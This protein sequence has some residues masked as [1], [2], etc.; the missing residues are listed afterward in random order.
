MDT[1]AALPSVVASLS[2]SLV[3]LPAS[4]TSAN[5]TLLSS[6]LSTLTSDLAPILPTLALDQQEQLVTNSTWLSAQLSSLSALTASIPTDD[7]QHTSHGDLVAMIQTG[8]TRYN[9]WTLWAPELWAVTLMFSVACAGKI[10]LSILLNCTAIRRSRVVLEE[11]GFIGIEQDLVRARLQKP[12]RAALGHLLNLVVG[13]A[14]LV[15]Q[16]MAWRLFVLGK[17]EPIRFRDV[18]YFSAAI[19]IL[20][21]GYGAD[22][23]FGD[24]R[25]EIYLHHFFTFALLFVGQLAVFETKSPKFFRMAQ[26]LILQ[27]TTE[28]TTYLAMV[29]Y[30]ISTY[31][32]LQNHRPSLQKRLLKAT[33]L[34]LSFTKVITF[35]QKIAPALFALYWL[36]RMWRSIDEMA[37]GRAWLGWS[38]III[39]LLLLLQIKFCDDVFPLADHIGHKLHGGLKPSRFGP[40]MSLLSRP[41]VRKSRLS[42]AS[43]VELEQGLSINS[44]A[45][46][47]LGEADSGYAKGGDSIH[48]SVTFDMITS[49][50]REPRTRSSSAAV[51]SSSSTTLPI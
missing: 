24:V 10:C 25:P 47:Q 35:P 30:H 37:W 20:L 45:E 26:Y 38:T 36:G 4:L 31:L 32:R 13:T 12:A 46:K 49:L 19:K 11:K 42:P 43:P 22:L 27:A 16:L 34:L 18:Q 28:Q 3:S 8:A 50:P 1:I 17:H 14:A 9:I 29:C 21:V 51:S 15:L 39:S 44:L 6:L 40:V 23:L 7:L 41:F 2:A 33:W 48:S 5:L